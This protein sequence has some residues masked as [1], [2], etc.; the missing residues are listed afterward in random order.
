L[1]ELSAELQGGILGTRQKSKRSGSFEQSASGKPGHPAGA[2]GKWD[3]VYKWRHL[4]LVI[5]LLLVAAAWTFAGFCIT[6]SGK[7]DVVDIEWEQ[8]VCTVRRLLTFASH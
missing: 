4:I 5:L 3:K 6:R 2:V 8:H 7:S 1:P